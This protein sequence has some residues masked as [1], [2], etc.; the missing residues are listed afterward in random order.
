MIIGKGEQVGKLVEQMMNLVGT[1]VIFLCNC[2]TK[3]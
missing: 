3:G 1:G 2:C